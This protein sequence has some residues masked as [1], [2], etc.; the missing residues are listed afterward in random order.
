[1]CWRGTAGSLCPG[2]AGGV[3]SA[4]GRES[5]TVAG[6]PEGLPGRGSVTGAMKRYPRPWTVLITRFGRP[7]APTALRASEMQ[8]VSAAS[9]TYCWDHSCACSLSRET[10]WSWYWMR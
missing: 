10:N 6:S 9:L 5:G 4:L 1:A 3:E 2:V 8:Y 7:L